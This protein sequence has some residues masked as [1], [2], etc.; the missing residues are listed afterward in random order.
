MTRVGNGINALRRAHRGTKLAILLVTAWAPTVLAEQPVLAGALMIA[1]TVL[2]W[3]ATTAAP[4][5]S[6]SAD[7]GTEPTAPDA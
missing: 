5:Q 1:G 4:G 3:I 6:R 2:F 7:H